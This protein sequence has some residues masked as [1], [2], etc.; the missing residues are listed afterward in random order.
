M[1]PRTRELTRCSGL[2]TRSVTPLLSKPIWLDTN[3][4]EFQK[5]AKVRFYQDS[6]IDGID[7]DY[8]EI[9]VIEEDSYN[10]D[11]V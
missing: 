3:I 2:W 6:F 7:F 1:I 9:Q 4:R 8:L 11:Y 5:H 10:T